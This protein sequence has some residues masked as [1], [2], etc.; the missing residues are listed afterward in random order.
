VFVPCQS[1]F[2]ER[3]IDSNGRP[4]GNTNINQIKKGIDI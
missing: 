3:D 1:Q 4:V 2:L